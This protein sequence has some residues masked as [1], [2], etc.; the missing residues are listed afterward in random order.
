[1]TKA[2]LS[3]YANVFKDKRYWLALVY[4][5]PVLA[6]PE[7]W[8]AIKFIQ[9]LKGQNINGWAMVPASGGS[10]RL[11][12]SNLHLALEIFAEWAAHFQFRQSQVHLLGQV[13][14]SLKL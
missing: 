11:E 5:A 12:Q 10:Y 1:M 2:K 6:R 13:D 8:H 14:T 7:D 9:A 3:S 4:K